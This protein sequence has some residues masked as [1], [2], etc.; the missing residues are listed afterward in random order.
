[1]TPAPGGSDTIFYVSD[2]DWTMNVFAYD[3]RTKKTRKAGSVLWK[4]GT[5]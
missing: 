1:M 5:S 4:S 3:T 2:R